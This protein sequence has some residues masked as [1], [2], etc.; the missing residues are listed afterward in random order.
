M[1]ECWFMV[2]FMEKHI[3]YWSTCLLICIKLMT[4]WTWL[5]VYIPIKTYPPVTFVLKTPLRL[6]ADQTKAG[7]YECRGFQHSLILEERKLPFLTSHS[8]KKVSFLRTK[9][10]FVSRLLFNYSNFHMFWNYFS[11]R[12]TNIMCFWNTGRSGRHRFREIRAKTPALGGFLLCSW[13]LSSLLLT[14][15]LDRLNTEPRLT[16]APSGSSPPYPAANPLQGK[17]AQPPA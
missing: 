12:K 4:S 2:L 13:L 9:L 1:T 8:L 5:S 6:K 15:K 17:M 11:K 16:A 3:L 14:Q 10:P 7:F